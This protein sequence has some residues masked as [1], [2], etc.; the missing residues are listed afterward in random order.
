[1]G[2]RELGCGGEG[3]GAC[4]E[5]ARVTVK[6]DLAN[7]TLGTEPQT[8]KLLPVLLIKGMTHARK[9]L[10]YGD[11]SFFFSTPMRKV[12]VVK[13]S[14]SLTVPLPGSGLPVLRLAAVPHRMDPGG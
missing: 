7:V 2:A 5:H 3:K 13:L 6:L 8:Y 11:E 4:R 1:M 10:Q 12:N 14:P 9:L